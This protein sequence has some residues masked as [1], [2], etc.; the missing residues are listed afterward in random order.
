MDFIGIVLIVAI[1]VL[2]IFI[3]LVVAWIVATSG[4]M[5][6]MGNVIDEQLARLQIHFNKRYEIIPQLI[7]EAV[8]IGN[9]KE[10]SFVELERACDIA[11]ANTKNENIAQNEQ[12]VIDKLGLLKQEIGK[13]GLTKNSQEFKELY[14][15]FKAIEEDISYQKSC[16]N[17]IAKLYNDRCKTFPVKLVVKISKL[18]AK[19]IFIE[20]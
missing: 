14:S 11:V 18:P 15:K 6:R 20:K 8:K 7:S 4:T 9:L 17:N 16:Y 1:S 19:P 13:K 5:K 3:G 10:D 12:N 2:V